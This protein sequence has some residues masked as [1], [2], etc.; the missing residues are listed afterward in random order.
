MKDTHRLRMIGASNHCLENREINDYYATDP[1]CVKDLLLLEDFNDDILE[2]C[3]GE[4]HIANVLKLHNKRV[5]AFDIINRGYPGTQIKDFITSNIV[6]KDIDIITNPPYKDAKTFVE[7]SLRSIKEG[8]KVAMFL[9]L[10]FLESQDRLQLFR[11]N[12]P[13][14]IY[15]YSKRMACAKNGNFIGENGKPVSSAIAYAW[16]IWVKGF[17]GDPVIKWI[18]RGVKI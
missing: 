11:D 9:K 16:F 8:N 18:E 4:G 14:T 13:K 2:P 10:I 7:Q 12:P 15:V 17:K 5:I 6:V 1:E 3:V